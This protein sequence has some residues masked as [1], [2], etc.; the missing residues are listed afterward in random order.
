MS[1]KG[2]EKKYLR[3]LAHGLMPLVLV[4]RKG[5]TGELVQSV[6][7]ALDDHELI[8]VRFLEFKDEK[9]D[10]AQEIAG[11]TGSELVGLIGHTAVFFRRH[12][13]PAKRKIERPSE[14]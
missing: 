5:V 12:P 2:S 1:L 4:G 7:S 11:K 6:D 14:A 13:N 8:K 9:K 3:G 10:L